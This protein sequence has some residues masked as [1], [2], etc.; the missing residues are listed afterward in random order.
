MEN[1]FN[2]LQ[3]MLHEQIVE[4]QRILRNIDQVEADLEECYADKRA[5]IYTGVELQELEFDMAEKG[6][7][8]EALHGDLACVN[9]MVRQ[10]R[11]KR[12][13]VEVEMRNWSGSSK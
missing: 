11:S 6:E 10:L 3:D 12:A 1:V 5:G 8:L 7:L 2:C 4:R 9:Y 13:L